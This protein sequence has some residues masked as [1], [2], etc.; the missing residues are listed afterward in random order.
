MRVMGLD[1]GAKTVGVAISDA[2]L[3]TA[4]PLETVKRERS[5]KLRQTLARI[6]QLIDEYEVD[7]IVLGFPKKLNNE[8]G[9]RCERT[10]EFGDMI[11]RRTGLEIIY[12]DERLTTVAADAV[13]DEGGVRK[14]NRKEFIDKIAASLILQ[15]YLD[16]ISGK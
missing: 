13:L 1:Y 10:K 7:K 2:M 12:W 9:D 3:M 5:N 16:S 15:G 14:E 4:Q 11:E 8:E 6:E